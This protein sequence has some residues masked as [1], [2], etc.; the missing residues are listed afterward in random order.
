MSNTTVTLNEFVEAIITTVKQGKLNGN[1]SYFQGVTERVID[2]FGAKLGNSFELKMRIES[3]LCSIKTKTGK[4][5]N[6]LG[7]E[8][9]LVPIVRE[10][11][12]KLYAAEL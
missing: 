3:R 1:P 7:Y 11:Y 2:G 4:P 10:E 6:N 9:H 8:K 5:N 12:S